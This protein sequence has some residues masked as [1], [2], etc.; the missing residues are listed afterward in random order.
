MIAPTA[1]SSLWGIPSFLGM[2]ISKSTDVPSF[3]ATTS[4]VI[5]PPLG[6]PNT[7]ILLLLLLFVLPF[8][9]CQDCLAMQQLKYSQQSLYL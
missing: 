7:T 8:F 1:L 6:I 9:S 4:A 2:T 5:T 3:V